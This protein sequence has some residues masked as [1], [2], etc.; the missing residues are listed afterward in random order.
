MR[1][2]RKPYG[3]WN[4]VKLRTSLPRAIFCLRYLAPSYLISNCVT[5]ISYCSFHMIFGAVAVTTR[6]FKLHQRLSDRLNATLTDLECLLSFRCITGTWLSFTM[7]YLNF[8]HRIT[9]SSFTFFKSRQLTSPHV[10]SFISLHFRPS[11]R[12]D[13]CLAFREHFEQNSVWGIQGPQGV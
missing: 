7:H 12:C 1:S 9:A 4:S 2:G 6:I 5:S 3:T 13:V 11:M 8:S 10:I